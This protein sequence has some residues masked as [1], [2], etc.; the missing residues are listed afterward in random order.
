MFAAQLLWHPTHVTV[1]TTFVLPG[2]LWHLPFSLSPSYHLS[3]AV[4]MLSEC[5]LACFSGGYWCG[6]TMVL[7]AMVMA[8]KQSYLTK[9]LLAASEL[10]IHRVSSLFCLV[11]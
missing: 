9:F 6:G 11:T 10:L 1:K 4:S 7:T 8:K 5:L 3:F 2:G